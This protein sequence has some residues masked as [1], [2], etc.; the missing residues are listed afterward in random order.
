MNVP[1]N[2]GESRIQISDHGRPCHDVRG[3]STMLD[4]APISQDPSSTPQ[5]DR[6]YTKLLHE[7]THYP[8]DY[9]HVRPLTVN[10]SVFSVLSLYSYLPIQESTQ[11]ALKSG[12]WTLP[13]RTLRQGFLM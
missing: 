5:D 13:P 10:N 11:I 12:M 9:Y 4:T 2:D 7:Y 3:W 8:S 1:E 6:T